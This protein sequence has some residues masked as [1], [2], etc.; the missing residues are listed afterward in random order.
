MGQDIV[1]LAVAR[2]KLAGP[3]NAGQR[4]EAWNPVEISNKISC[5]S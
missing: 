1:W 4:F 3:V 2:G 5:P